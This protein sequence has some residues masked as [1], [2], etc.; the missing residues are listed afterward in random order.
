MN[1]SFIKKISP[2]ALAMVF[3]FTPFPAFALTPIEVANLV[4]SDGT[5][6][7][8]F[9]SWVAVDGDTA[10]IGASGDDD[11]GVSSGSVYVFSRN[12][13]T[14]EQQAKL[15]A[16]DGTPGDYFGYS[17]AVDGDTAVIG[18]YGDD[19]NGVSSGSVYVFSRNGDTWEQQAKLTASDGATDDFFGHSVTVDGDTAVIGALYDDDNGDKSGSAYVFSRNGD[20]WEQQAKLTASDGDQYDYFGESVAVDGD[21]A[22]IG[23]YGDDD[24]GS[25]SGSAYV[26]RR[27]TSTW[28]QQYKLIASDG[29]PYDYFGRSVAVD[30]DT[31]VIGA[32]GDDD[33]GVSSGSVYV[34]SRNAST[35]EQ[36][37]KLMAFDGAPKDYFGKSVA[38]NGDT[39]LIG[40]YYDDDNG[41]NSGSAYVFRRSGSTWEQQAKLTASDGT[42]GDCF[43]YWVAVDGDTAVIGAPYD[44]DNGSL[45]GSSYVFSLPHS[46]NDEDGVPDSQDNCP[47]TPNSDQADADYD[48]LGDACDVTFDTGTVVDA[49]ESECI[50]IIESLTLAAPPGANG[51]LSKLTGNGSVFTKVAK[52]EYDYANAKID[53]YTYIDRLGDALA[54]LDGLD[55]Q[56]AGKIARGKSVEREA[57]DAS[58]LQAYSVNL[59]TMINNLISNA[60]P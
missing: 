59:R 42:T 45:S 41:D 25:Y 20:T 18:A 31:A 33:N 26:F 34:F 1:T 30:D 22:V 21:T 11:N 14:W 4:A 47:Y 57:A 46:D 6:S 36:Q 39:A 13:D 60:T 37:Y 50:S 52:A 40:A 53:V 16:S 43:G 56:L 58:E 44:D 3:F 24:N 28:V 17:V 15:T 38:V 7:D 32:S 9:G 48:K 23:A 10:V 54:Q 27:S 51:M 5:T 8:Y 2:I 35:W 49:L 55:E 12:G 29:A 19:D